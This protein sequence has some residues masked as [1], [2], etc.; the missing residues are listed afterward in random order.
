MHDI[1]ICNQ[2]IGVLNDNY[3][4]RPRTCSGTA[5]LPFEFSSKAVDASGLVYYGF[6][7]FNP[8][9]G[10]WLIRDPIREL[11]YLL[12]KQ[13][14]REVYEVKD[15]IKTTVPLLLK[16]KDIAKEENDSFANSYLYCSNKFIDKN[17]YLGLLCITTT[18]V[19]GAFVCV[20]QTWT[21]TLFTCAGAFACIRLCCPPFPPMDEEIIAYGYVWNV[22]I[23]NLWKV[24]GANIMVLTSKCDYALD[25]EAKKSCS[26]AA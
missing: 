12:M 4:A 15:T 25:E 1:T 22:P 7:F 11:G 9:I 8:I 18:P 17:D 21:P 26:L 5:L 23:A 16:N 10:R 6:R 14:N 20:P 3:G 19:Y 24:P 2:N 13:N